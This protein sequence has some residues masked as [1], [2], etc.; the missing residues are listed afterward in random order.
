MVLSVKLRVDSVIAR[1]K[2]PVLNIN[3][4]YDILGNKMI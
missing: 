2:L 3:L 4:Q 1:V